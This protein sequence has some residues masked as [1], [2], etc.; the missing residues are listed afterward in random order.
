M[1]TT[2]KSALANASNNSHDRGRRGNDSLTRLVV[3]DA[4]DFGGG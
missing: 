1:A 3:D 4:D 2:A